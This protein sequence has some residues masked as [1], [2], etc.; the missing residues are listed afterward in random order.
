[1]KQ[2]WGDQLNNDDILSHIENRGSR[3]SKNTTSSVADEE[4]EV[5]P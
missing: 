4:K 3:G 1:M 5:Y 2:E